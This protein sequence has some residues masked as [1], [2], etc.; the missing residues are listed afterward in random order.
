MFKIIA[1]SLLIVA[2]IAGLV[3]AAPHGGHPHGGHGLDLGSLPIPITSI[4]LSGLFSLLSSPPIP[5]IR[6]PNIPMPNL[7][8]PNIPIPF[9]SFPTSGHHGGGISIP[10]INQPIGD[11]INT[12]T[13]GNSHDSWNSWA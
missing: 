8:L 4:N 9:I 11:L 2:T 1:F 3:M 10:D 6:I 5:I 7:G 13:G 12:I